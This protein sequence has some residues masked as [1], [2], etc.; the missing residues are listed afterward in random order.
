MNVIRQPENQII[1]RG[2]NAFFH[3]LLSGTNGE[4]IPVQWG[5]SE[6]GPSENIT[7]NSTD[8]LILP[9]ANS[10]LVVV[11]PTFDLFVTCRGGF[12][13]FIARLGVIGEGKSFLIHYLHK[14]YIGSRD[15][16]V[17]NGNCED[18]CIESAC[19]CS[20]NQTLIQTSCV[21]KFSMYNQA[22]RIIVYVYIVCSS[23]YL[24]YY[25]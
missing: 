9:P 2:Q 18:S 24:F 1:Y 25:I 10:V 11:K 21:C 13:G 19:M 12:E 16:R 22:K 6:D 23:I 8:Y 17:D 14:Y 15:C 20:N 5:I 7:M 4:L 3:C